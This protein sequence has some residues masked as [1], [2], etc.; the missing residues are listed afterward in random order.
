[1]PHIFPRGMC[2]VCLY[3]CMTCLQIDVKLRLTDGEVIP[4]PWGYTTYFTSPVR[5]VAFS[6]EV[7]MCVC[8]RVLKVWLNR[9]QLLSYLCT[10]CQLDDTDI[11]LPRSE[12]ADCGG[13]FDTALGVWCTHLGS[14]KS[15][16][17]ICQSLRSYV[18]WQM[19]SHL[20]A[21]EF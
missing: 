11:H 7:G 16:F 19:G 10:Q 2:S 9:Q 6:G 4:K 1:M 18:N 5:K 8:V 15:L 14:K 12:A 21:S 20:E 3:V 13:S 17:P